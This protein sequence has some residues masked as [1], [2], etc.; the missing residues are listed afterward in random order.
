MFY[1]FFITGLISIISD[2]RVVCPLLV[3]ARARE[4]IAF[5]VV[6]QPQGDDNL[7]SVDSD[8]LAIL[9]RYNANTTEKRRYLDAISKLFYYYVY[10]GKI[11]YNLQNNILEIEQDVYLRNEYKNCGFWISHEM[12]PKYAA[13][14]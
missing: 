12:V 14:Y 4:N 5:Y 3:Q 9:G 11:S 6:T 2:I 8:I 13:Y 7:A 10:H 1:L